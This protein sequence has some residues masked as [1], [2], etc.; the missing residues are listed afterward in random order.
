MRV[1][2]LMVGRRPC[3]G[4]KACLVE[5]RMSSYRCPSPKSVREFIVEGLDLRQYTAHA[6]FVVRG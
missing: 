2:T 1:L 6:V 5:G 4:Y 3:T